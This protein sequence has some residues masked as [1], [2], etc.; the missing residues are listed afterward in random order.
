MGHHK[1]PPLTR[2]TERALNPL[3]GKSLVIYARRAKEN[4]FAAA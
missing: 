4:G 2:L 3:L 1:R